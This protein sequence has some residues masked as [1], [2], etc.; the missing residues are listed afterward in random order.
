MNMVIWILSF[1]ASFV[2]SLGA[3]YLVIRLSKKLKSQQTILHYVE[4]HKSKQGTATMGGIAFILSTLIVSI[5]ANGFHTFWLMGLAVGTAFGLL[6]FLD[7][8]IKIK[9][10]QNLGLRPYQKIIGQFGIAI[11]LAVYV[12]FFSGLGGRIVLPFSLRTV[13]IGFWVIPLI[14][15]LCLALTNAVNLTDG[16]DGLASNVSVYYFIFTL[17]IMTIIT[18]QQFNLA[19]SEAIITGYKN[20]MVLVVSLVGGLMA[21]LVFNTNKASIF[22]GDVG[23][24]AIGGYASAVACLMGM[25]LFVPILGIMFVVTTLSDI[26]QVLHYKRTH[27]RVFLM[28]P[29]HHHF[30]KKGHSEAKI[31]FCYS[32]VTI[33]VGL[34]NLLLIFIS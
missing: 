7:D 21:F 13:D 16:L 33:I 8:F 4:E 29:L 23:S 9:Y 32:I 31:V 24:L 15:V 1:L 10:K 5:I 34:V 27:R 30:Q 12:Y 22:M 26:I 17:I 3:T 18:Q 2:L 20:L 28:A 19:E 25:E 6:G 11:I 14:I